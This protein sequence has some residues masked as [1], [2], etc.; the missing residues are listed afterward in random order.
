MQKSSKHQEFSIPFSRK[1][2]CNICAL[3]TF[4]S[5]LHLTSVAK[6]VQFEGIFDSIRV[7][8]ANSK[9]ST[10]NIQHSAFSI[11]HSMETV[12][13]IVS[14]AEGALHFA[15]LSF[16]SVRHCYGS[17]FVAKKKSIRSKRK[18]KKSW[19]LFMIFD[20][21]LNQTEILF[22]HGSWTR[23]WA[24]HWMEFEIELKCGIYISHL[25]FLII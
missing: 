25:K 9:R 19:H 17:T 23:F 14:P 13:V 2:S 11:Q 6:S 18:K 24:V 8:N 5:I 10:F 12:N 21:V 15:T 20:V 1:C 3:L 7:H 4:V 22:L 16:P